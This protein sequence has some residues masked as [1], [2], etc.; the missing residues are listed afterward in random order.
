MSKPQQPELRRSGKV[1]AL[2]PDATETRLTGEER[3][4]ATG[5][6]GPVPEEQRPG[7]HPEREQDKPDLD[8]FAARLGIVPEG[9]EPENAPRVED[10]DGT[11]PPA[12]DD[13]TSAPSADDASPPSA[14]DD[15]SPPSADDRVGTV[16]SLEEAPSKVQA[17]ASS[18][19]AATSP[20]T[21]SSSRRG[22]EISPIGLLL[23]GPSIGFKVARA[24]LRTVLRRSR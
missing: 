13:G 19:P 7:H 6:T 2:D 12:V 17:R 4:A 9:E 23:I 1:A 5:P 15:A 22:I 8:D 21:A 10:D 24:V 3:P 16:T 18:G 14:D 20:T 11:S